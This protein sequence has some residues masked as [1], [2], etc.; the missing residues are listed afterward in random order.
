MVTERGDAGKMLLTDG[1]LGLL[2]DVD[3]ALVRDQAVFVVEACTAGRA[4][5]RLHA[6]VLV[7]VA[8]ET[9]AVAEFL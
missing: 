3:P 1:T 2:A 7:E 8:L 4:G 5:E 6:A 9:L